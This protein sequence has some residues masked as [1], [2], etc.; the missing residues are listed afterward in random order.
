MKTAEEFKRFFDSRL[1]VTLNN[2]EEQRKQGKTIYSFKFY[3]RALLVFLALDIT[4]VTLVK[5]ELLPEPF[6]V[7]V[8][9][10]VLFAVF[11]P[12]VVLFKRAGHILPIEEE[13]KEKVIKPL[14]KF[15]SSDLTYEPKKGLSMNEFNAVRLFPKVTTFVSSNFISGKYENAEIRIATARG[16]YVR[17]RSGRKTKFE[18]DTVTVFDGLYI[19]ARS[20]VSFPQ[21][22][23]IRHRSVF[24]KTFDSI[25]RFFTGNEG[26][27]SSKH[28]N[29]FV[30]EPDGEII[31]SGDP[32]FDSV[33][34]IKSAD[35][36]YAKDK[37]DAKLILAIKESMIQL[38][39]DKNANF[40]L[41]PVSVALIKD[42]VHVALYQ[43]GLFE[44]DM[45]KSVNEL[46]QTQLCFT[47][48][49]AGC[50]IASKIVN[51][52]SDKVITV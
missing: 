3:R 39:G 41:N 52:L 9:I 34:N 18:P 4:V 10:S 30:R 20:P 50:T 44:L 31:S 49:K 27:Q 37:F 1:I 43:N 2:L 40:L 42:E 11:Y 23:Y 33:F 6:F 26:D 45:Y 13:Y 51:T 35:P 24:E 29:D 12:L 48:V 7:T 38:F 19:I 25:A 36:A 17:T 16:S 21:P 14:V 46:K 28:F 47:F 22:V 8:F 5:K 15:I 32:D